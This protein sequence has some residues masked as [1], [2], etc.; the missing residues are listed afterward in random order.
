MTQSNSN[1]H[2]AFPAPAFSEFE[3]R[4]APLADVEEDEVDQVIDVLADM[5]DDDEKDRNL[6]NEPAI[7]SA[8]KPPSPPHSA[9]VRSK[10]SSSLQPSSARHVA[11][12]LSDNAPLL[13][14]TT[15]LHQMIATSTM[16][17]KSIVMDVATTEAARKYYLH[18]VDNDA[19]SF[20]QKK[21][22]IYSDLVLGPK[23]DLR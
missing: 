19:T 6:S 2:T 9:L 8:M 13:E 11:F 21:K 4:S 1:M 20:E 14:C 7:K 18:I 12:S 15:S 16:T 3:S 23:S 17:S 5:L 22:Q 10:T